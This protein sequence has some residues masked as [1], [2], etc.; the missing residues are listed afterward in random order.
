MIMFV[1][2]KNWDLVNLD[3]IVYINKSNDK[4]YLDPNNP[5]GLPKDISISEEKFETIEK[6]LE[7]KGLL[8]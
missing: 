6:H 2:L 4:C 7:S 3:E 1:K 5:G 8:I